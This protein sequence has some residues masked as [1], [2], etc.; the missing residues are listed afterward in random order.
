LVDIDQDGSLKMTDTMPSTARRRELGAELRRLREQCGYNGYDM[1]SRLKWTA[2]KLSRVETGKRPM[3]TMEVVM[4]TAMCGVAGD[5][6]TELVT[7]AGESDSHRL[8]LHDGRIPDE[9]QS[10]IFNETSATEIDNI[11]P[12]YIPGLLQTEDYCRSV[13]WETG[14]EEPD[15]I[16]G[17]VQT[18]MSRREAITKTDPAQCR[19]YLYENAL[20][21]TVGGPQVM[22]EQ[23]LHMLFIGTR[24]QCS[25]RVI[26]SSTTG[27]G[28]TAGSFHIFRF[29]EGAPV[30][31]VQHE[32]TS[33]FLE[34]PAAL[35]CYRTVLD[36]LAKVA[37]DEGASREYISRIASD[38]ERRGAARHDEDAGEGMAQEQS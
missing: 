5:Q 21:A 3:S 12:V 1:A 7:M 13:F 24:P 32:Y 4:Y 31:C 23:M 19:F 33:Q 22:Y 35:K 17:Y 27:R 2:S 15:A 9:M 25:I 11:E 29:A 18:R 26:P 8:K 30:V 36:R 37:L 10:L 34:S 38:Y 16:E 28:L 20:R 6:L 14:V